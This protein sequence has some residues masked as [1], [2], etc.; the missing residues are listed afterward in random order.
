MRI[1]FCLLA[2]ALWGSSQSASAAIVFSLAPT[3][4]NIVQ[5][6]TGIFSLFL[7]SDTV[8]ILIDAVDVN[9]VAGAGNG[10]GGIFLPSQSAILGST[11]FDV[12][13]TPGQAFSTNFLAGGVQIGTSNTLY[14]TLN[15]STTGVAL[16]TYQMTLNGLSANMPGAGGGAQTTL[17][18][19]SS[20]TITAV[21]EASSI[22]L[23]GVVC[24]GFVGASWL[25]RLRR[26]TRLKLV[27]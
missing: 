6:T 3:S 2:A 20:Y 15:L 13:T 12:T 11:A 7:R 23:T 17:A 16:G 10:S 18:L 25:T 19:N 9:V 21:P 14:G 8:P 1:L 5:G 4:Q 24:C 22:F 26:T 27:V